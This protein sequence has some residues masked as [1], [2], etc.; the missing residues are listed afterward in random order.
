MTD[1]AAARFAAWIAALDARHLATL[2]PSEV[3]RALRALSS[4]YVE[5]RDKLAG[6]QA[7]ATAGKRAAFALFYAP[8]HFLLTQQ[9][10]RALAPATARVTDLH[11]LGCGT[12]AAGAAWGL[13]SQATVTGTDRH[14][15]A[16]AEANWAYRQLGVRGRAV[17]GD[18]GRLPLRARPGSGILAAY[19]M[20]EL[21]PAVRDTVRDRLL[22]AHDRGAAVLVIEPIARRPTP[23]WA[24][25]AAAFTGAG[26]REDEWRFPAA[27][28]DRQR[29]L[30]KAA[31]LKP[32]S[33]TGRTLFL[34]PR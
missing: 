25:W 32:T 19:I 8:I 22:H 28:P 4:C 3:A 24:P 6:G 1:T 7:L 34:P 16:V 30:A 27:L 15:W 29:M 31:G 23:W 2:T 10:V 5:R 21:G 20:N 9:I 18:V 13:D 12:G 33:L 11:D 17:Q 26:G 14:P